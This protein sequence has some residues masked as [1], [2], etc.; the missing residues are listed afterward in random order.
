MLGT[1]YSEAMNAS[2]LDADGNGRLMTMGCYGIGID[3]LMAAIVEQS[4]DER[5][6]VWPAAVSPYHVHLCALAKGGELKDGADRLY[7]DLKAA[8]IEVLYDD[9][10][11]RPG[12]KF[13][14]ADLIGLPWRVTYSARSLGAGGVEVKSRSSNETMVVSLDEVAGLLLQRLY[15]A[16]T[17][18]QG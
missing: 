4:R 3:R 8:S 2:F 1:K 9:R 5:G 17:A 12:V 7:D 14:D 16:N 18:L 15:A 11:V 6:I 10:P 13:N